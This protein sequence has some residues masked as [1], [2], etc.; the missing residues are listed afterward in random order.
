RRARPCPTEFGWSGGFFVVGV[1]VPVGE[2]RGVEI[3][4]ANFDFGKR[5]FEPNFGRIVEVVLAIFMNRLDILAGGFVQTSLG[6]APALVLEFAQS[7]GV[8]LALAAQTAFLNAQIVQ[9]ALIG[10]EDFGFN[11]ML[12]DAFVVV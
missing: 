10:K 3:D 6:F 9:L 12:A 8:L 1:G 11:E 7:S 5:K 4:G 2:E